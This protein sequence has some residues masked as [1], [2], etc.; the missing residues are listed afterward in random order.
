MRAN[1][2]T[3]AD[4]PDRG[5][6]LSVD[7]LAR[8]PVGR[9]AAEDAHLHL[10]TPDEF[11]FDCPRL[12]SAWG[13]AY[14]GVFVWTTP[15]AVPGG[16]WQVAHMCMVLGVRGKRPFTDRSVRS[17]AEV[18]QGQPGGE[19]EEVRTLLRRV[20]PGPYLDLFGRGEAAGWVV[21]GDLAL[22]PSHRD[23]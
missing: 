18:R 19:V 7:E 10:L 8:L 3:E 15:D 17:S 5:W 21:A 16:Y 6:T 12:L 14:Q 22:G 20:S 9:L 11:L 13:F 4:E 2:E 1:E 23:C